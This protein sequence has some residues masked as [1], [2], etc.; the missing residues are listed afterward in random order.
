MIM[1]KQFLCNNI[2]LTYHRVINDSVQVNSEIKS[3][4]VSTQTFESQLLLLKEKFNIVSIDELLKL[5]TNTSKKNLAI[6]F[7]DGYKDNLINALPILEKYNLPA[8]IYITTR[9]LE[10]KCDIWWYEIEKIVWDNTELNFIFLNKQYNFKIGSESQKKR[11]YKTLSLMFKNLNY[12]NQ[13]ILLEQITKTKKRLQFNKEVLNK[14]DLIEITKKNNFVIGSHTH[15][16]ANLAVL[17]DEDCISELS[18]SKQI[19][20]NT[21]GNKIVH[22]AFPYGSDKDATLREASLVEKAGY[23]SA[24][25]TQLG[26]KLKKNFFLIPRIHIGENHTGWKLLIKLTWLYKIYYFLRFKIFST[27]IFS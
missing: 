19:L 9:F 6:T 4:S 18:I 12:S 8:T 10:G 26:F 11:C 21:L 22:F 5:N 20:E 16:H 17:S 23:E 27:K 24:V 25:T 3:I 14:S 13:N 7:D 15:T 2:I 1:L